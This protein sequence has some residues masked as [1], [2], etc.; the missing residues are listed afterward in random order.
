MITLFRKIRYDLMESN[1][2]GKYLKYAVGEIVLV[3]IGIL[4][5]L[6]INN[7]N[8]S[9]ILKIEEVKSLESLHS[10]FLEN[11]QK[12]DDI[13]AL[14]LIR[15]DAINQILFSDISNYSLSSLDSLYLKANFNWTYNPSFGIYNSLINSGKIQLIASDTLKNRISQFKELVNDYLED[16]IF[17][18]NFAARYSME[19][20]VNDETMLVESKFGLRLRNEIETLHDKDNY[21][22]E[23]K[24]PKYRNRL[25]IVLLN[26]KPLI[27]VGIAL[28][29]EMV[30]L[31]EMIESEVDKLIHD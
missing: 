24:S 18:M 17:I 15:N 22:K 5:A 2:T 25:S 30:S 3:V 6:Q 23:F 9:K 1:K 19:H 10:E 4:I 12:F 26:G 8:Q 29:K 20:F 14:Q 7:W 13:H 27:S 28:R 31:I 16:E 11:L 21:L